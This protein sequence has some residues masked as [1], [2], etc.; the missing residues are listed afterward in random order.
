MSGSGEAGEEG[1]EHYYL[2][3]VGSNPRKD[4]ADFFA[5]FPEL[6]AD[7]VLPACLPAEK[8]F[9]RVTPTMETLRIVT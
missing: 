3:A 8:M 4:R 7:V 2:R 1:R 9:R 5:S 6:A